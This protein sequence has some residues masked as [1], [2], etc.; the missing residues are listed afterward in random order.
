MMIIEQY[1]KRLWEFRQEQL[2][3]AWTASEVDELYRQRYPSYTEIINGAFDGQSLPDLVKD[4]Y[5]NSNEEI[6][7]VLELNA[8]YRGKAEEEA[9]ALETIIKTT[10]EEGGY[11][12]LLQTANEVAK[13]QTGHLHDLKNIIMQH[14]DLI[15]HLHKIEKE[16]ELAVAEKLARMHAPIEFKEK[17]THLPFWPK[18]KRRKH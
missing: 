4:W 12:A 7:K 9:T 18:I 17:K 10:K 14:T 8:R 15:G 6:K 2:N 3:R 11:V 1:A 16:K 5:E 13:I